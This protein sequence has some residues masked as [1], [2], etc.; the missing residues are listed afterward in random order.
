MLL[1]GHSPTAALHNGHLCVCHAGRSAVI[2][3]C[4]TIKL[5]KGHIAWQLDQY[6][7]SLTLYRSSQFMLSLLLA[8]RLV[9]TWLLSAVAAGLL[10]LSLIVE[11]RS[12]VRKKYSAA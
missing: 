10:G 1:S 8:F 2:A 11:R 12:G 6:N 4:V 5:L 9:S 7:Y 3:L